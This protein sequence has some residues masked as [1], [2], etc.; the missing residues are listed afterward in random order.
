M[1]EE[2]EYTEYDKA[3]MKLASEFEEALKTSLA[4]PY[5]FAPGYSH[6]RKP[7]GVRN[8][9]IKT[10]ALYKS[11]DVNFNPQKNEIIVSMLDYWAD[12]NYGRKPGKY[13]PIKP[14]MAWIRAKG[15]NKSKETGRFQKFNIKG[16]AFAV[17]KNI[18]RF[19]IAATYFYD[20]AFKI[21]K[22]RFEDDAIKALGID[23]QHFFQ[24]IIDPLEREIKQK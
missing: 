16:M 18:E 7:F 20:D 1:A 22:K 15:F 23:V 2:I 19:G 9:K 8:M 10:G 14:L 12:V 21:F 17:S 24:K 13:V 5:P 3:M 11:I 6:Q 4:K